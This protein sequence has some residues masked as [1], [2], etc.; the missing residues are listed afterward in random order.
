MRRKSQKHKL[1]RG[2]GEEKFQEKAGERKKSKSAEIPKLFAWK[3]KS[4]PVFC[5]GSENCG[6]DLKKGGEKEQVIKRERST[7]QR[8]RR[9][10]AM[11]SKIINEFRFA[12]PNAPGKRG[13]E[14]S[15]VKKKKKSLS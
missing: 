7:G 3:M 4:N 12:F 1:R 13:R 5:D 14:V 8:G 15:H 10:G 2:G 9:K 11:L 6:P